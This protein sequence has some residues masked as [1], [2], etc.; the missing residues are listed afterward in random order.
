VVSLTITRWPSTPWSPTPSGPN[1]Y[2]TSWDITERRTRKHDRRADVY[3]DVLRMAELESRAL[4]AT[5]TQWAIAENYGVGTQPAPVAT[6]DVQEQA[7]IVARLRAF[8]SGKV[9]AAYDEWR[10]SADSIDS[11]QEHQRSGW[12]LNN[13][14]PMTD[15]LFLE[16]H[17]TEERA[18]AALADAIAA[19]LDA[20]R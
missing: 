17:P 13:D 9:R 11:E 20:T 19:E 6:P 7:R 15:K 4:A 1:S 12:E 8:G 14:E 18:R 3:L 2:T 10:R 5:T 16:L